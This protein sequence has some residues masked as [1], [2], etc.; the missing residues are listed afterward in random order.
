MNTKSLVIGLA[1]SCVI[2]LGSG[3]ADARRIPSGGPTAEL[4][5]QLSQPIGLIAIF[6]K[7]EACKAV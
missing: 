5:A 4:L 2:I 6:S 7:V 1:L 3:K